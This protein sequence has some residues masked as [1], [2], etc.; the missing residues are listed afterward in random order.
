MTIEL[1]DD[2]ATDEEE[3]A[4]AA[5]AAEHEQPDRSEDAADEDA[6]LG[7]YYEELERIDRKLIAKET[8]KSDTN[9]VFNKEIKDI[10]KERLAT[11]KDIEAYKR[12]ERGL[13][14]GE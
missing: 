10:K 13:F 2:P 6:V 3:A 7:E 5:A 11:L 9:K 1:V 8:E 14:D 4:A 12:G